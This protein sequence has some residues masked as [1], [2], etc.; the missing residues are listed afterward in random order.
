M[1]VSECACVWGWPRNRMVSKQ[2]PHDTNKVGT[3]LLPRIRESHP[4]TSLL[5]LC[6]DSLFT[7][8]G[9]RTGARLCPSPSGR[10]PRSTPKSGIWLWGNVKPR[11][12]LTDSL[13]TK[14]SG[15]EREVGT[16][17][18]RGHSWQISRGWPTM[19]SRDFG[20]KQTLVIPMDESQGSTCASADTRQLCWF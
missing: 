8:K 11:Q 19:G 1:G 3:H 2:R 10:A 14:E 20:H 13:K 16:G 7:M 4:L 17:A 9:L 6:P 5:H 12:A 15:L 18:G